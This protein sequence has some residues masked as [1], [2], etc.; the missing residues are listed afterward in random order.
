MAAWLAYLKSRL[1]LPAPPK[2]ED[3]D[4]ARLAD[5]LAQRLRRLEE[6]RR[7]AELLI[8]RPRLG[9]DVFARGAPEPIAAAPAAVYRGDALRSPVRLCAPDAEARPRPRV[10]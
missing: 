10:A 1:L 6:I 7:A 8:D 4:A 9:R 5:A 2:A 3:G